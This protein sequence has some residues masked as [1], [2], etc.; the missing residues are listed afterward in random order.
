MTRQILAA[1]F[2]LL[3]VSA[4]RSGAGPVSTVYTLENV[5]VG[6]TGPF[7][8]TQ[9]GVTAQF[10]SDSGPQFFV[11]ANNSTYGFQPPFSGNV[12][13]DGNNGQH[14]GLLVT[15]STPIRTVSVDVGAGV[16]IEPGGDSFDLIAYSGGFGGTEIGS[17][18][19]KGTTDPYGESQGII[20]FTSNTPFDTIDI[21]PGPSV[22]LW[23]DNLAISTVALP[24]PAGLTLA[25]CCAGAL[26]VR[27][28]RRRCRA[29]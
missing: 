25:A 26:A 19:V 23:I 10:S 29:A 21:L 18:A 1:A 6:T 2:A 28:W 22:D 15:F 8:V 4:G 24:E 11:V 7:C 17:T 12:L 27:G 14:Q 16:Q 3:A 13:T 9:D 5:P 20:V